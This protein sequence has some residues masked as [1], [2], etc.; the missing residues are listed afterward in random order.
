VAIV[1][2]AVAAWRR[3]HAEAEAAAARAGAVTACGS[4]WARQGRARA[5]GGGLR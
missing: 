3:D 2:A 1:A 4:A 5:L